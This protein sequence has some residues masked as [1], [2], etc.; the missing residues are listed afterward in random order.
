MNE[1]A[2]ILYGANGFTGQRI[3]EEA[4]RRGQRPIL[5]GRDRAAIEALA[6]GLG[7]PSRVFDLA[8]PA[9]LSRSLSDVR[10]VLNC[11]GPFGHTAAVMIEACLRVG[12]HYL[13]ITGEIDV[14][15]WAAAQHEQ[16]LRAGVTLLPAVGFDVVPSD[17]LA[18]MLAARLPGA[19][20]LELAFT[21]AGQMS[22]GTA[23]T[24]VEALPH[25]G[26]VRQEGRIVRVPLAWK[27]MEVPFQDGRRW[28]TTVPWGDVASAWWSTGIP[29]VEVYMAM[30]EPQIRWMQRLRG[31]AGLALALLPRDLLAG[32]LRKALSSSKGGQPAQGS[33][34]GRVS[35]ATGQSVQATLITPEPYQLTVLTA[36]AAVERV[37]K[38]SA[39]G[40]QTPSRLFGA[41]F[42][43]EIPGV[44]FR[45]LP[46][47]AD[48]AC[49]GS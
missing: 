6:E 47:A 21:G 48:A 36:L 30:P 1:P 26:R 34:W 2:W 11:A 28:T 9:G 31:L 25:G 39:A 22:R 33:L 40:F 8:D 14:I 42:V 20:R 45:E 24:V 3:A 18:A 38:L 29:N 46:G 13:D 17:C 5:A 19:R 12:V 23:R 35:D 7:C 41:A 49:G 37:W 15:E 16:A 32:L 43:L 10:G 4:V 27:A 44:E